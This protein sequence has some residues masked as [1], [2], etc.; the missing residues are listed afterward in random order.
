MQISTHI[1]PCQAQRWVTDQT[2]VQCLLN[3]NFILH[4][5]ITKHYEALVFKC[6][7]MLFFLEWPIKSEPYLAWQAGKTFD[8]F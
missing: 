1:S 2:H 8:Y 4:F 5:Q 6:I 7:C 3:S